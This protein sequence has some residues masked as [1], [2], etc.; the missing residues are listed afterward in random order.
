MLTYWSLKQIEDDHYNKSVWKYN[1]KND[2]E[3]KCSKHHSVATI[4]LHIPNIKGI[5]TEQY[6][7]YSKKCYEA[8]M[9][10]IR[11]ENKS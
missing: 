3:Y 9:R 5:T 7:T 11:N 6:F 4:Q 2:L 8:A 1:F 10:F